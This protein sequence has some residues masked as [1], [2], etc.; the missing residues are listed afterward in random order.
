MD[1]TPYHKQME[2]AVQY[3]QSEFNGLQIGRATP[4]LIEH[5]NV[6][7]SYG[8]MKLNQIA[9]ITV[10]DTQTLKVEPW[11]KSELSRIEK[12]IYDAN[13]GLAPQNQ[14]SYSL[15]KIPA[16]TQERRQ[17]IIRN[18]KQMAEES[19]AQLRTIRHDGL[20]DAKNAHDA[21]TISEDDKT[22][23]EKKMDTMIKDMSH[24]ID[25]MVKAKSE[26]I[27]KI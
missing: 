19:K 22:H 10:M 1:T 2:K 11:D 20:K 8:T 16:L 18:I 26:E 24:D 25:E 7:A 12:A 9:H 15:V 6:E 17:D 3:L 4:G 23:F 5:L 27:L 13:I 14:G 21:K